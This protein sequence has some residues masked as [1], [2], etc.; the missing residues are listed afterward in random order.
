[1]ESIKLLLLCVIIIAFFF[2]PVQSRIRSV[3]S[4]K[5]LSPSNA[6]LLSSS[7]SY[8]QVEDFGANGTDYVDDSKAIQ[9]AIDY[10]QQMKI[11]KVTL[12][13]H[14][15]YLL[16]GPIVLKKGVELEMG[17]NTKLL[18]DG[19]FRAIEMQNNSSIVNG[20]IMVVSSTFDSQVI[21][22]DGKYK[23]SSWDRARIDNVTI[24]NASGSY[25][26]TA[27]ALFAGGSGHFITYLNF[28]NLKIINFFTGIQ[29]KAQKPAS[30]YSWVNANRFQNITLDAC[31]NSIEL[32]GS[33]TI[34]N[35]TSGNQF[36]GLQIQ[37][38]PN[39]NSILKVS[40]QDNTFEAMIWDIGKVGTRKVINFTVNSIGNQLDFN[41]TLTNVTNS[42]V[43]NRIT[44]PYVK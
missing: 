33:K 3:P 20:I 4:V 26:G 24:V 8:I 17:Q 6:E 27:L 30:G 19:N 15:E 5:L 42:G 11:G 28:T 9:Q 25:K 13:D 35:E 7:N 10:A 22:L 1:M 14:K 2:Y 38:E 36:Q 37:V 21:Y 29:L 34:P 41:L 39:T 32:L 44:T 31:I 43:S 23:F 18:I 40:G 12:A 16:T